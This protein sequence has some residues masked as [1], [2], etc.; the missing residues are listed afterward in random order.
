MST[1]DGFGQRRGRQREFRVAFGSVT[2]TAGILAY[3]R[4]AQDQLGTSN[5]RRLR[6][7]N[8]E[9]DE[10]LRDGPHGL[11]LNRLLILQEKERTCIT[12]FNA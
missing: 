6:G 9:G 5:P 10:L 8:L 2:R 11:C 3:S 4:S 7:H 12:I 1:V